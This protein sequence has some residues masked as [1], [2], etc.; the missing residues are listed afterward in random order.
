MKAAE[1]TE[2][3]LSA[4]RSARVDRADLAV[5][6]PGG[7][8]LWQRDLPLEALPLPWLRA[9]NAH[10]ADLYIRPARGQDWPMVFLDDVAVPVALA[11]VRTEGGLAVQTSSVGGCHLWLPCARALDEAERHHVQRWLAGRLG[12]DYGS[13]SGEHLGRLAGFKNWKRGGCWVNVLAIPDEPGRMCHGLVIPND[14]LEVAPSPRPTKPLPCSRSP[15]GAD[16]SPSGQDWAWVCRSLESGRTPESVYLG[17][18]ARAADRR[19]Q[20][21]ERYARRTVDQ[22]LA[23]IG[24][25]SG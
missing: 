22:A 24:R 21:A 5:R 11:T 16:H 20:D 3:M 25:R 15:H 9:E 10:G 8:M 7:T 4:W 6:R 2:A 23:R 1:H 19:G 12:A 13:I 18:V 17:L 14:L